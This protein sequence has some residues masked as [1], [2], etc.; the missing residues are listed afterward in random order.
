MTGCD[1]DRVL[2]AAPRRIAVAGA[3]G[4][5][6]TTLAA[7]LGRVL[8]IPHVEMDGLFH[9]AGWTA[10]PHFEEEVRALVALEHWTT[11]WQYGAARPL[12]ASRADLLVWVDPPRL[13]VLGRVVRRTL[14]RR[15][16]RLELWNGN[17]E[18]P[19]R[20]IL[21]DRDHI[22]RWSWRTSPLVRPR[23]RAALGEHPALRVVRIR[24]D[25]DRRRLLR[26]LAAE[27]G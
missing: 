12:I 1:D 25:A 26:L 7:E 15:L 27:A 24:S 4:S 13:V 3:S 6:K 20:T 21:T 9:H 14:I 5:G 10:N 22:V 16:L 8:G 18:P 17:R 23:L 19:L 11:E 2:P